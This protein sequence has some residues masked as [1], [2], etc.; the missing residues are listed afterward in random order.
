MLASWSKAAALKALKDPNVSKAKKILHYTK[1]NYITVPSVSLTSDVSNI[2][3]YAVC[4]N[5]NQTDLAAVQEL[6]FNNK[7]T[8][9]AKY[10]IVKYQDASMTLLQRY[11]TAGVLENITDSVN[12]HVYLVSLIDGETNALN[13]TMKKTVKLN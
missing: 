4:Y 12:N 8:P 6:V 1:M 3:V 9:E 11:S 7:N 10:S 5:E 2:D 13:E